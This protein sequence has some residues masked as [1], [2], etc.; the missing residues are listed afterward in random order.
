MTGA[1]FRL[2]DRGCRVLAPPAARLLGDL[3][4]QA[5]N[6]RVEALQARP[7]FADV[8]ALRLDVE[9]RQHLT[10]RDPAA[11]G[12]SGRDDPACDGHLDLHGRLLDLDACGVRHGVDRQ[13]TAGEPYQPEGQQ[14]QRRGHDHR[15]TSL[16]FD[17]ELTVGA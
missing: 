12:Q 10:R 16:P 15:A 3:G 9:L 6:L 8:E 11:H 7:L 2:C 1:G 17:C 14:D 13:P 5:G 4:L